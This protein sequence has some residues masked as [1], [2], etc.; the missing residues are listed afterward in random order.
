MYAKWFA[1]D[2][3]MSPAVLASMWKE[4][5]ARIKALEDKMTVYLR[6]KKV[7]LWYQSCIYVI[8][9]AFIACVYG[10]QVKLSGQCVI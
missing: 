10:S 2:S 9:E 3:H 5:E 6:E 8:H 4:E 7:G 1:E